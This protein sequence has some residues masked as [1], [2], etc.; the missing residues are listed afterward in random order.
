MRLGAFVAV[1]LLLSG[2][3]VAT[4]A[5][6]VQAATGRTLAAVTVRSGP[7]NA[8]AALGTIGSGV[9]VSFHCYVNGERIGGPYGSEDIWNALDSGGFVPDALVF[10]GSNGAVVSRCAGDIF[11]VGKYPVAWTGGSGFV[12]RSA[13]RL[14]AAGVGKA[15]HDG[16][17]VSVACET[18]G[19]TVTDTAG[20][21][22]SIW[23][24]LSSGGYIPNVY[25]VTQINGF[26]PG[27]P[28]CADQ[29]PPPPPPTQPSAKQP[30]PKPSPTPAKRKGN[31]CLAA[32]GASKSTTSSIFGGTET[33]YDRKSS[34]L[35]VCEGFG[36]P[37]GEYT[38]QMQCAVISSLAA[39]I[40]RPGYIVGQVCD[41]FDLGYSIGQGEWLSAGGGLACSILSDMFAAAG[42]IAAAG[43][44]A[45]TGPGAVAVGLTTYRALK[46]ALTIGCA[47]I[48]NAKS[49]GAG[50]EA[51]HEYHVAKDISLKGKC[52]RQRTTFGWISWSAADC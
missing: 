52:L 35:H 8:N 18:T 22:L 44:T 46:A 42:G 37:A 20:Y 50:L 11:G 39:L 16:L 4:T 2:L 19:D 28:R 23:D 45:E 34:L 7:G 43:V 3:V 40:G 10:T 49:F 47:T 31:P 41:G 48:F 30:A 36:S 25:L 9:T 17:L 24:R 51:D 15:L 1:P 33:R 14:S 13:P 5:T 27:V 26:T 32:L 38:L 12:P 6:A 29:A 21:T